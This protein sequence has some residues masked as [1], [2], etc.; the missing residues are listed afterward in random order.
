MR[1][2]LHR[3]LYRIY[4]TNTEYLIVRSLYASASM[5]LF[6]HHTIIH[7]NPQL[8]QLFYG[9][10]ANVSSYNFVYDFMSPCHADDDTRSIQSE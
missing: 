8:V 7:L 1:Y 9:D 3:L 5:R 6:I 2:T 4:K 10:T